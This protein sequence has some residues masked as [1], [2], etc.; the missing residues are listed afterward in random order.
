MSNYN[1][2]P[3][4]P[5]GDVKFQIQALMKMMERVNFVM[6]N[7]CEDLRRWRNMAMKLV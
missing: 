4:P 3:P 5:E 1:N 7:V 6:G 2:T